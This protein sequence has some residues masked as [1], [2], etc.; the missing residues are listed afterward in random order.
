MT[1][2]NRRETRDDDLARFNRRAR[3]ALYAFAFVE[4]VGVVVFIYHRVSRG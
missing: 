2:G 1:E 3:Y 4:F